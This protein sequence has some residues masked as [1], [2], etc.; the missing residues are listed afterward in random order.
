MT[1]RIQLGKTIRIDNRATL[2]VSGVYKDIPSNSSFSAVKFLVPWQLYEQEDWVKSSIH[3]WGNYSFQAFVQLKPSIDIARTS[4]KIR[5]IIVENNERADSKPALFLYSMK[6]W[7]LYD[8]FENGISA[9]GRITLI[10]MF[11]AI[12]T[13]ILLLACINFINLSTARSE[14]NAKEVGVR[15]VIGSQRIQLAF[16][17]LSESFMIVLIAFALSL[18]LVQLSLAWFNQISGKQIQLI[19]TP[20]FLAA[21]IGFVLFTGLLAGLYP[22]VYIIFA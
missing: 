18:V 1:R 7:H 20:Y 5:D 2:T 10:W 17:F 15:K 4:S 21:G 11:G 12:G 19:L 9:G 3:N 22:S 14:K 8:R 6:G 13:F 16:R